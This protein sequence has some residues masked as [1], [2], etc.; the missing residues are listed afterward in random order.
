VGQTGLFSFF[1][2]FFFF[3]WWSEGSE[4]KLLMCI[5]KSG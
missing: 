2:F 3:F 4:I 1:S 5:E